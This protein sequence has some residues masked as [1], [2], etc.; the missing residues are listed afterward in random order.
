[1]D[2]DDALAERLDVGHVVARQ[3]D[4]RLVALAVGR[5]EL[6]KPLLH[7]DVEADRRLVEEDHRRPVE[8][9]PDDL[10]LHALA[11]R[12]LPHRLAH[13]V[14]DLEQLD[15]LV[16]RLEELLAWDAVDGSG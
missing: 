13:E 15:Q 14:T 5:D 2:D 4:R 10:H 3:H 7:R 9:R 11:E 8:E 12:Q 16:P 6:A 1:M